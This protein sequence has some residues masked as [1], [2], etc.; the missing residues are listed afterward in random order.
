MY[1]KII[2]NVRFFLVGF[3]FSLGASAPSSDFGFRNSF[4]LDCSLFPGL[5]TTSLPLLLFPA[6]SIK[7]AMLCE[8][9]FL[10]LGLG[11]YPT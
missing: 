4:A 7:A 11:D 5:G 8:K 2:L 3:V 6:L 10:L 9:L 1:P